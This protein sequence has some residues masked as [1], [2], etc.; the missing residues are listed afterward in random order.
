MRRVSMIN[1]GKKPE[2]EKP[3]EH[4]TS[5]IKFDE[6]K[7]VEQLAHDA[8]R[9]AEM[10]KKIELNSIYNKPHAPSKSPFYTEEDTKANALADIVIE[11]YPSY[12]DDHKRIKNLCKQLI[13]NDL[14]VVTSW[15][16]EFLVS[17]KNLVTLSSTRIREFNALSGTELLNEVL[18]FSKQRG[19]DSFFKRITNKFA[20][21][22][23][24][25]SRVLALKQHVNGILPLICNYRSECKQNLMALYLAVL[26]VVDDN[27][28]DKEKLIGDAYYNRRML[29]NGALTNLTMLDT[30]LNQTLELI[31]G[32]L[33]EISHIMDVV[34]P[35]LS[36]KN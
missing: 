10:D 2:E 13:K 15:G 24:Y 6:G 14:T 3:E 28:K 35:A 30:Q 27:T 36:M 33:N 7:R 18:E 22:E 16:E 19:N 32:M 29:L 11:N 31:T 26:S 4:P 9:Q 34:L 1:F 21:I 23:T 25:N 17:Q 5:G 12:I 20:N 8:M